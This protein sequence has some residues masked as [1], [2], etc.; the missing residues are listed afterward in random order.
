MILNF[1]SCLSRLCVFFVKE[2]L[3]R[4]KL[5]LWERFSICGI[6][7]L[8]YFSF[9]FFSNSVSISMEWNC[10]ETSMSGEEGLCSG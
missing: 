9:N 8:L 10:F 2:S 5:I 7:F 3:L 1:F 6:V 4:G